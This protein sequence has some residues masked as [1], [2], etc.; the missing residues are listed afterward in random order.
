MAR[1]HFILAPAVTETKV[2]HVQM[3][4]RLQRPALRRGRRARAALGLPRRALRAPLGRAVL[5]SMLTRPRQG[6]RI[7]CKR[8]IHTAA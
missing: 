4:R 5:P 1:M 6:P 2:G 7:A 3:H 8:P